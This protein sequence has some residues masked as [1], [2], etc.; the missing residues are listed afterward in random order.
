MHKINPNKMFGSTSQWSRGFWEAR[1]SELS[2]PVLDIHGLWL[3]VSSGMMGIEFW[4]RWLP[5]VWHRQGCPAQCQPRHPCQFISTICPCSS[6]H[7]AS[8]VKTSQDGSP[9]WLY[10]TAMAEGLLGVL[11]C[12]SGNHPGRP[13]LVLYRLSTSTPSQLQDI[14]TCCPLHQTD[15]WLGISS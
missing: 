13:R 8:L 3:S 5:A 4:S 6:L 1:V 7:S 14:A 12:G 9:R 15:P 2:S 11:L 10:M